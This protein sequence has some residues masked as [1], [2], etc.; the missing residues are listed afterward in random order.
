MTNAP[1]QAFTDHMQVLFGVGTCAGLTDG[2]LLERFMAGR[3][4]AGEL[5]FEALVTRH[6]PMVMRVCRNVLDD[7]SRRSRCL[8]GRLSGSAQ[9]ER[10]A[11]R[12]R[13]SVGS[14]LYGVAVR[15]TARARVAAIRRQIRDRRTIG[16]A[17]TI[18]AGAGI[19]RTTRRRSSGMTGPRSCTKS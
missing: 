19:N 14:W 2:Q 11:I 16:A 7:P 8:S 5:A 4:E 1:T 10:N 9:G 15:V 12:N 6:G 13:E 3:D 18:A 17:Q